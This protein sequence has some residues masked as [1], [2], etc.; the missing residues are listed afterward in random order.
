MIPDRDARTYLTYLNVIIDEREGRR[1]VYM[2]S[3]TNASTLNASAADVWESLGYE[4]RR[5]DCTRPYIHSGSLRCLVNV[6][7][8]S[9]P[10]IHP[11]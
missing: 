1:I 8:R 7:S 4:V 3:Y 9:T 11:A 6:L 2:P 10:G 5:V